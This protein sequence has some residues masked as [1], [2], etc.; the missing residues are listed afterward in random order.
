MVY[1]SLFLP[2]IYILYKR[3][4]VYILG[5]FAACLGGFFLLPKSIT[6]RLQYIIKYKQDP[7]SYLRILF[8]NAAISSF[9]KSPIFGMSTNERIAFN[10]SHF[11]KE[12]ILNYIDT[13][14]GLDPVGITNTHNMYLHHLANYGIAGVIPLIYFLFVVIPSKLVKLNFHKM[15]DT[16]HSGYIALETGMKASYI[17]YLIQ[18]LTEFNLNKK[19][20]IFTLAMMLAILNFMYKKLKK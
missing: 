5:F 2:V 20:M 19:P 9:K 12:G 6:E 3:N 7:S 13:N 1:I 14:Y 8:W 18:G 15:K 11:K 16:V 4:K 17:A 10:M